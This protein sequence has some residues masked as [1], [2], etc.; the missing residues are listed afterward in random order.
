MAVQVYRSCGFETIPLA[1]KNVTVRA[2]SYSEFHGILE[3]EELQGLTEDIVGGVAL[4]YRV[5]P[6]NLQDPAIVKELMGMHE[7]F[8]QG[9][10][11]GPIVRDDEDY[12]RCWMPR[13]MRD[14]GYVLQ[15]NRVKGEEGLQMRGFL[16]L[17]LDK[18][19]NLF[20]LAD[21]FVGS[22]ELTSDNG[23]HA[24]LV[25]GEDGGRE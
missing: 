4:F 21:F 6:A 18:R 3:G 22:E 13:N 11:D 17:G 1:F 14:S 16:S 8:L 15:R 2:K 25:G 20:F 10:F 7:Q 5:A 23:C 9:R 12:W 19:Q 24:L